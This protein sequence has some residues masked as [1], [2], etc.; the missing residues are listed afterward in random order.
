MIVYDHVA[1]MDHLITYKVCLSAIHGRSDPHFQTPP[2][3]DDPRRYFGGQ[4]APFP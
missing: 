1:Y 3:A 2:G 4:S